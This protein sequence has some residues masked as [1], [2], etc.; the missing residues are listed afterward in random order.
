VGNVCDVNPT[1]HGNQHYTILASESVIKQTHF[2]FP[3]KSMGFH[4][5]ASEQVKDMVYLFP[6]YQKCSRFLLH[7]CNLHRTHPGYPAHARKCPF[8]FSPDGL[9]RTLKRYVWYFLQVGNGWQTA[10]SITVSHVRSWTAPT[11]RLP[12]QNDVVTEP[13]WTV[14]ALQ[15]HLFW[16]GD[17]LCFHKHWSCILDINMLLGQ[18]KYPLLALD[19][20]HFLL[21]VTITN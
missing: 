3:L 15:V 8:Q 16:T 20:V 19:T 7:F 6:P 10:S 12:R 17:S 11:Q 4:S 18:Q 1:N 2:S 9:H 5:V 14:P 21:N 13:L